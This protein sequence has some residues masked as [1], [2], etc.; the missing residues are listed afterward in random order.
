MR[1]HLT[2]IDTCSQELH[3]AAGWSNKLLVS[4]GSSATALATRSLPSPRGLLL[5]EASVLSRGCPTHPH[6][7]GTQ[8]C[9]TFCWQKASPPAASCS[10]LKQP[11]RAAVMDGSSC[12]L[13]PALPTHVTHQL[14]SSSLCL[15]TLGLKY[16]V[17][18][19]RPMYSCL[20]KLMNFHCT[21]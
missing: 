13:Q 14:T 4:S 21:I 5:L 2:V 11:P 15:H 18:F 16:S 9:T 8:T 1:Y 3:W 12:G 7:S 10:L 20:N 17:C 19:P 6:W